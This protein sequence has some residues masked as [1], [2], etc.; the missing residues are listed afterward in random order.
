[1]IEIPI[2]TTILINGKP[3]VCREL[4]DKRKKCSQ[5]YFRSCGRLFPGLTKGYFKCGSSEVGNMSNLLCS[6]NDR[7]DKKDVYYE[8]K[9]KQ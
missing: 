8:L 5:C 9:E 6:E 2:G 1:M 3:C 7:Q 4:T